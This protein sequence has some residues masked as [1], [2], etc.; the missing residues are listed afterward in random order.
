MYSPKRRFRLFRDAGF[1]GTGDKIASSLTTSLNAYTSASAGDWVKI[2]L[3]EY[4]TLQTNISGT[5]FA[6]TTPTAYSTIGTNTNFTTGGVFFTNIVSSATP[7]ISA[8]SYVYAIAFYFRDINSGI[9]VYA[10]NSTTSY[11]NFSKIG[12]TLPTTTSGNNYYVLKGASITTT[13]QG[14]IAMWSSDNVKHGFGLVSDA[15]GVRYTFTSSPSSS[16]SLSSSFTASPA[17]FS[18]QA[19]ATTSKQW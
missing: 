5:S 15:A 18:L 12:G 2:T 7:A 8:N 4:T 6:G 16:S 19:L 11:T 1:T 9:S 3:T 13:A 14:N 17:A 10:N